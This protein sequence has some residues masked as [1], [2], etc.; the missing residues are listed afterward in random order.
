MGE[1]S[2][3]DKSRVS[4]SCEWACEK[5]WSWHYCDQIS[6]LMNTLIVD[7]YIWMWMLLQNF[8][9]L[10]LCYHI[11]AR[12]P[13]A[14][15]TSL[16][17]FSIVA[18]R[19][20]DGWAFLVWISGKRGKALSQR[21]I[22]ECPEILDGHVIGCR[23]TVEHS[24]GSSCDHPTYVWLTTASNEYTQIICLQWTDAQ[25]LLVAYPSVTL[26]INECC[27]REESKVSK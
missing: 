15:Y 11:I 17:N 22:P 8:I 6:T 5:F 7:A 27:H 13:K 4:W 14:V 1:C 20:D 2:S 9:Y 26:H 24:C 12:C 18:L 3:G 23:E 16:G 21:W 19:Q 25:W 10:G